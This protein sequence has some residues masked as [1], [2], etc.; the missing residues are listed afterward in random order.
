MAL[1]ISRNVTARD[2]ADKQQPYNLR[3]PNGV[4]TIANSGQVYDITHLT[5]LQ[6]DFLRGYTNGPTGPQPGRRALA[7][8]MHANT[9][10]N[11]LSTQ[12]NAPLGGTEILIDGSQATFVPANRAV[13][14]H[15]TG[16]TN[17]SV[18][19]E[20]Y[21]LSFKPGEV[22]TCA[23][24]HGINAVDQIGRPS[25]TNEPL[26]LHQLLKLWKTNSANAYSLTVSNGT[27][28]GNYGAGTMLTL[29]ANPPISGKYFAGW[30]G[31]GISITLSTNA[32]FTMPAGTATATA[33]YSNLPPPILQK[34]VWGTNTLQ[35]NIQAQAFA[36]QSW[37][38]QT[39]QDLANW[40]D[41]ATN[42]AGSNSL[43]QYLLNTNWQSGTRFFRLRSP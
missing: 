11:Y 38:L 19:K 15:L 35:F 21:W 32:L 33:L 22:R 31:N 16:K 26:A 29:T 8:P 42:T 41:I 23:N 14:W 34:I 30:S 25:P 43:V 7:T 39:S 24:C 28:G 40:T 9:N 10:F 17:E 36:L 4:S 2:V 12:S 1:V 13:T 6:A 18:V 27:G 37:I 20:R 3:V 5:F